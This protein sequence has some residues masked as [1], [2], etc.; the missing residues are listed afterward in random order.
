[1]PNQ[2]KT[3]IRNESPDMMGSD[4]GSQSPYPDTKKKSVDGD[5]L[6]DP[7]S[8]ELA[9]IKV[10]TKKVVTKKVVTKKKPSLI[11]LNKHEFQE[12]LA[13]SVDTVGSKDDELAYSVPNYKASG[14]F[15]FI[16]EDNLFEENNLNWCMEFGSV[17][18]NRKDFCN[19]PKKGP[20]NDGFFKGPAEN[21][22][23]KKSSFKKCSFDQDSP[24]MTKAR[25][26]SPNTGFGLG[27]M[28]TLEIN[29]ELEQAFIA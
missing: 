18:N 15:N 7:D 5:E 2:T 23:N 8:R 28:R 13:K 6:I 16:P 29:Q 10:V 20:P 24:E 14:N 17:R 27:K 25:V 19:K 21:S 22:F 1:V 11:K 26:S 3:F 4:V 9:T 12:D